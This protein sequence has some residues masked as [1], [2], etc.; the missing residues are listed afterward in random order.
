V[1]I[2]ESE[3]RKVISNVLLLEKKLKYKRKYGKHHEMMEV[4]IPGIGK[5]T[6][7][8]RQ[9]SGDP[10]FEVHPGPLNY[11]VPNTGEEGVYSEPVAYKFYGKRIGF[12]GPDIDAIKDS[13]AFQSVEDE[14]LRDPDTTVT[15][16]WIPNSTMDGPATPR[17][18][19]KDEEQDKSHGYY[20]FEVPRP[21]RVDYWVIDLDI[22]DEANRGQGYE[23]KLYSQ[24]IKRAQSWSEYGVFITHAASGVKYPGSVLQTSPDSEY[25][26]E[27][28]RSLC[29][30]APGSSDM[31]MFLSVNTKP[32]ETPDEQNTRH[33][34][35]MMDIEFGANQ[36]SNL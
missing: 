3:L 28:W 21:L 14:Y 13:P 31:S 5:V 1:L 9:S 6:C 23:E 33:E 24:A 10:G 2:T 17:R 16:G 26:Q 22:P 20:Y 34:L 7:V 19:I 8:Q 15:Q 18:G 29:A 32:P 11:S 30:A 25:A 12:S 27:V 36:A 35:R 4:S